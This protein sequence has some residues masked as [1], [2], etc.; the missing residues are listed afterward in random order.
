MHAT[1][2]DLQ[3]YIAGEWRKASDGRTRAVVNPADDSVLGQ[4]PM[5]SAADLDDALEAAQRGFESWRA[6]PPIQRAAILQR[7]AQLLRERGDDIARRGCPRLAS[8]KIAPSAGLGTRPAGVR[9]PSI[10]AARRR[11]LLRPPPLGPAGCGARFAGPRIAP[12]ACARFLKQQSI[13]QVL[14]VAAVSEDQFFHLMD[15][16]LEPME[17]KGRPP[18]A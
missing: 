8:G 12:A 3:L 6:V 14:A 16:A 1:Y 5:A 17:G 10:A 4:L 18:A 9:L 13:P 2:P 11:V 7:G 15:R